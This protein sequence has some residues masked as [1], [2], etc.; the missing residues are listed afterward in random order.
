[1]YFMF[2][3]ANKSFMSVIMLN[4][5]FLYVVAPK[6]HPQTMAVLHK[7]KW[8]ITEILFGLSFQL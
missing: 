7:S 1:M 3:V 5:V 6:I 8:E 2:V 4:V